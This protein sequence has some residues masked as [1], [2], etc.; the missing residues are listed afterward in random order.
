MLADVGDGRVEAWRRSSGSGI[1]HID[2]PTASRRRATAVAHRVVVGHD[3]A[4]AVAEGHLLGAGQGGDV[5]ED[6]GAVLRG[7]HEGV[8]EDQPALGVGVEHL[9]GACRR[10]W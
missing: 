6:V 3:P 4:G 5:D 8:G 10:S 2:S 9:D 1:G 7:A